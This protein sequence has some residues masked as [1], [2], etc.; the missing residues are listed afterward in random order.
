M[1]RL[2]ACQVSQ[3][4]QGDPGAQTPFWESPKGPAH[5]QTL[6]DAPGRP[7]CSG[8]GHVATQHAV[9]VKGTLW[10]GL[11]AQCV[12][13]LGPRA[14]SQTACR[15]TSLAPS[16]S[17]AGCSFGGS[18]RRCEV[19]PAESLLGPAG[20]DGTQ[21]RQGAFRLQ[22][23]PGRL[24]WGPARVG[25]GSLRACLAVS[26]S[27]LWWEGLTSGAAALGPRLPS[28]CTRG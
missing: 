18:W 13:P 2:R 1:S 3:T 11:R 12:F 6:S 5:S 14:A 17:R 23:P 8:T 27:G 22:E 9:C 15:A 10:A 16:G 7:A 4:D 21:G 28:P 24:S 26:P 19:R 20:S 25:S